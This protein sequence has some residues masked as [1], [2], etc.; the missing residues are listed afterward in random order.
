MTTG[1][2]S[3]PP[4]GAEA[5]SAASD[6]T[7]SGTSAP[8]ASR[9]SRARPASAASAASQAAAAP[10]HPHQADR[11]HPVQIRD[12]MHHL[13]LPLSRPRR[14]RNRCVRDLTAGADVTQR[15]GQVTGPQVESAKL[16]TYDQ[17]VCSASDV[18]KT[19]RAAIPPPTASRKTAALPVSAPGL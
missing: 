17:V 9:A 6:P 2:T 11:L 12:L 10:P 5:A 18:S 13:K 8:M 3:A 14:I 19:S 4:S 1:R 15:F 7:P 16:R